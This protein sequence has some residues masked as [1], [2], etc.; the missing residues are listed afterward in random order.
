MNNTEK[1]RIAI[2]VSGSG[3]NM[4]NIIKRAQSGDLPCEVALVVS[5]QPAALALERAGRLG[6]DCV[7]IERKNFASKH[8]FENAITAELVRRHVEFI[9]L[10]GYMKILGPEFVRR[11]QW[12]ILNIHPSRLP[13]YPGAH[14]I[15]DAFEAREKET[16]VTVHFVDEG[17]DSGPVILQSTVPIQ[18][19]DTFEGLEKRV[20]E[21]EYELYPKVI[22]LFCEG[23]VALKNGRVQIFE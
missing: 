17:V 10:A 18:S 7:V 16:G 12:K 23:K 8:E 22:R 9:A 6:V 13:K 1:K 15:K 3:T 19:D 14:S 2:F 20:H 5:D 11:W 21:A 4:E